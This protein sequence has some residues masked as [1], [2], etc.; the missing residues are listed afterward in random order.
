[1]IDSIGPSTASMVPRMRTVASAA[2]APMPW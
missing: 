1:L 2:A